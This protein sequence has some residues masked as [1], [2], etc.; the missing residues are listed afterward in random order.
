MIKPRRMRWTGHVAHMGQ[1]EWQKE[2]DH[3]KDLDAVE[4]V[5]LQW[6]LE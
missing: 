4:R 2:I 5:I 6:I 3:W 1:E